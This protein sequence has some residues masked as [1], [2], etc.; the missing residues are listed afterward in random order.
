MK[1]GFYQS[2]FAGA[3]MTIV[4]PEEDEQDFIHDKYM[5]ELVRGVFLPETRERLRAIAG[6]LKER[7]GIDGLILG[8]TELPLILED[9]P[10]EGIPVLDT[11]RIHVNATL[12]RSIS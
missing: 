11:T 6:R 8:G 5:T 9:A 1:G 4:V 2:A 7:D 12:S 3:G 10:I